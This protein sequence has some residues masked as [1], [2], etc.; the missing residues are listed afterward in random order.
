MLEQVSA[1]CLQVV[2]AQEAK[3]ASSS[4]QKALIA[5][6]DA[7]LAQAVTIESLERAR[8]A[9]ECKLREHERAINLGYSF[10]QAEIKR[11]LENKERHMAIALDETTE[12]EEEEPVGAHEVC[13][14]KRLLDQLLIKLNGLRSDLNV[15]AE[16]RKAVGNVIR[17]IQL[18]VTDQ[19]ELA[20][21][22]AKQSGGLW[23]ASKEVRGEIKELTTLVKLL[24]NEKREYDAPTA[25]LAGER[26]ELICELSRALEEEQEEAPPQK[27]DAVTALDALCAT[28]NGLVS[29]MSERLAFLDRAKEREITSREEAIAL[30]HEASK[31][32]IESMRAQMEEQH[33]Q[34]EEEHRVLREENVRLAQRNSELSISNA[35]QER[36]GSFLESQ[37]SVAEQHA[38]ALVQREVREGRAPKAPRGAKPPGA[39]EGFSLMPI[40]PTERMLTA[41]VGTD[42]KA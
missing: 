7:A 36:R 23:A 12:E 17:E 41:R 21:A 14:T 38:A 27:Q 13:G 32:A 29:R 9:A 2:Q 34:L 22:E 24:E 8:H 39:R 10:L 15:Y 18:M 16:L 28:L 3:P 25:A 5:G 42:R 40:E 20:K 31:A 1:H 19:L 26:L 11:F 37:L 35:R 30:L 33:R 4:T 6:V